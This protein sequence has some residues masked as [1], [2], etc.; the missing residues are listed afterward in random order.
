VRVVVNDANILIDL[1][2]VELL[3]VFFQ[4]NYE[5]HMA[6]S[7]INEFEN[8]GDVK[9]LNTLI[10]KG[11]LKQHRFGPDAIT[12]ILEYRDRYSAR[13][14]FPDCCCIYLAINLSATLLTGDRPLTNAARENGITVHGTLWV[15]DQLINAELMNHKDACMKLLE[16]MSINRRLP[17]SEC[18]KRL[19]RWNK[20]QKG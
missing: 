17:I 2:D 3:N 5:M 20:P 1:I 18:K 8:E 6:D 10:K 14:S 19:S 12:E 16:L 7:V 9:R 13:L 4:L 11:K 15:F